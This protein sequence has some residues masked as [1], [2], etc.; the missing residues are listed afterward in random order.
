[1]STKQLEG[2]SAQKTVKLG[3]VGV[4]VEKLGGD[5]S[6]TVTVKLQSQKEQPLRFLRS[7]LGREQHV[8][9]PWGC[10]CPVCLRSSQR[11]VR[12]EGKERGRGQD[13]RCWGWEVGPC[14]PQR[15]L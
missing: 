12:P 1:M 3:E 2:P 7:L 15:Q 14:R 11:P 13:M 10:M 4:G 9:K 8:Q 5:F 6:G